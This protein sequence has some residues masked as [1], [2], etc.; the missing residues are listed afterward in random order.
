MKKVVLT[1]LSLLFV[2]FCAAGFAACDEEDAHT[3][4]LTYHAG[5]APTCAEAGNAEYWSCDGCGKNFFDADG[6]KE[7]ADVLLPATGHD[8]S[9]WVSAVQPACTEEGREERACS[10]CGGTEERSVP[11]TGHSWGAWTEHPET[12]M[13]EHTCTVCGA[14][15][16]EPI[17]ECEHVWS[18]WQT[19]L[20]PTCTQAG[21]EE[22]TCSLCGETEERSVPATGH[23]WGAWQTALLPTCTQAGREERTCSLCGGTEER[24]VPATGHKSLA[25]V[26][27]LPPT[28][29]ENGNTAYWFCSDCNT[30][31]SDA[32]GAHALK[33]GEWIL[34]ATGHNMTQIPWSYPTC[35]A[36]GVMEHWYCAD[37]DTYYSNAAGSEALEEG[38]WI[39]PATGHT[40]STEWEFDENL[41]WHESACGHVGLK[42]DE[43]P[44]SMQEGVCAVCGY[45]EEDAQGMIFK[46][47]EGGYEL[48]GVTY[49]AEGEFVVPATYRGK[50]VLSLGNNA[51]MGMRVTSVV[52][53][54][55]L[56]NIGAGA[57]DSCTQLTELVVPDSVTSMGE[58]AIAFCTSLKKLTLPFVGAARDTWLNGQI[59]YLFGLNNYIE[60]TGN[61]IPAS[62]EEV[63]VTGGSALQSY[64]LSGCKGLR[65]VTLPDGLLRVG[66]GAFSDCPALETLVLPDTLE[67]LGAWALRGCTS[68]SHILLPDG[69]LRV[70]EGAFYGCALTEISLPASIVEIPDSAFNGCASLANV[71]SGAAIEKIGGNAFYGCTSLSSF[72]FAEGLRVVG[73]SAFYASALERAE[74]PDGVTEIGYGAFQ[75]CASLRAVRI[76]ASV[77]SVGGSAFRYCPVL[78]EVTYAAALSDLGEN[79]DV[80]QGSGEEAERTVLTVAAGTQYIPARLFNEFYGLN[81]VVLPDS[82]TSIGESAFASCYALDT[83]H[84]GAGLL[85]VGA[86]AFEGCGL[87]SVRIASVAAWSAIEF[88]DAQANPLHAAGRLSTAQGEPIADIVLPEGVARIGAYAFTD[89]SS[90]SSLTIPASVRSIGAGAFRGL[91]PSARVQAVDLSAWCAIDFEDKDSNPLYSTHTLCLEGEAVTDLVLP[92]GVVSVA[93]RA[94]LGLSGLQSVAFPDGL[95]RI[96][97][98]AFY[99][100]RSLTALELPQTLVGIGASAFESAFRISSLSL[101]ASVVSVGAGAFAGCSA[102]AEL[103][104]PFLPG[105]YL[106][107]IFG[108]TSAED[109]QFSLSS[110]LTSV[111][112]AGGD[113]AEKAFY[114][115]FSLICVELGEEVSRIGA[116]AFYNCTGIEELSV[117]AGV[118]EMGENV[119]GNCEALRSLVLPFLGGTAQEQGYLGRLFGATA[120]AGQGDFLPQSLEDVTVLGGGLA[121]SAFA[122]C[123]KLG[124]VALLSVAALPERTFYGCASLADVSL[125]AGMNELGAYAFYGCTRLAGIGLPDSLSA[126]GEGAFGG[127]TRL[128]GIALPAALS[129]LGEGAF[130]GCTLLKEVTFGGGAPRIGARAFADCGELTSISLPA[131][132]SSLGAGV[133]EGCAKLAEVAIPFVGAQKNGTENTHFGYLFGAAGKEDNGESLPEYLRK[134]T[135]AHGDVAPYAFY[136]CAVLESVVLPEDLTDIGEGAF[137]NCAGLTEAEIPVGTQSIGFAAFRGC[138]GMI[139]L[140]LPF[141]GAARDAADTHFGYIFGSLK[142]DRQGED[143]PLSLRF[144]T[145]T[146]GTSV[147]ANAFFGCA[148]LGEVVLCENTASV[149]AY[150]FSGCGGLFTIT[151]PASLGS[152]GENAFTGCP[153]LLE[154]F[155][156]SALPISAGDSG[157]GEVASSAKN[158]YTQE[159]GSKYTQTQDGYLF[160]Y[161]G[162][163]LLLVD[164]LGAQTS[165]VLPEVPEAFAGIF[166]YDIAPYAFARHNSVVSVVFPG[167]SIEVGKVGYS[168]FEGCAS[169]RTVSAGTVGS[170]GTDAFSGCEKLENVVFGTVRGY[171]GE[172]AFAG[173]AALEGISLGASPVSVGADAFVGTAY[174][175][176]AQNRTDGVLYIGDHLIDAEGVS[177]EYAVREGTLSIAAGAFAGN[178]GLTSITLPAS[179]VTIGAGAFKN[180]ALASAVFA[181][182]E[183]WRTYTDI[184]CSAGGQDLSGD[185]I[186]NAETIAS[187]LRVS[188]RY[189][190][191]G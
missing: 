125:S 55:G 67:S 16:R 85:R 57:F 110:A 34:P 62:L 10:L 38:E 87:T 180:T 71:T 14:S 76:P 72:P 31:Y 90:L 146:D 120:A 56:L 47:I 160:Y 21:R 152:I 48:R 137:E 26:A 154:V 5:V 181:D 30:Y 187:D 102:I 3:H 124:F 86:G 117:P 89:L 162:E 168:A 39:L 6:T 186:A 22:R 4:T 149:G 112:V 20:L 77:V 139:R 179:L 43:A 46:A 93:P 50:P 103:S 185:R 42:K 176:D 49:A 189:W 58:G 61:S 12:G 41:H 7:A 64:A 24:S 35:E 173:C 106:G 29:T 182:T 136:G 127:C 92:A 155:N 13:R 167:G 151:L 28:C 33:E 150:A 128:A 121:P 88:A 169:L 184:G 164:C 91:D 65:S 119:F 98:E 134:V 129:E 130:G 81:E 172:G 122:E 99:G 17:S 163:K 23:S 1:V 75:R 63:T 8:W 113:I 148:Q 171:I 54:N 165:L 59:A 178:G 143:L 69:L 158:V 37:C 188:E 126:I 174:F 132:T 83:V 19:A 70:G 27:A 131:E 177:G 183:W 25:G 116:Q 118:T 40:W 51:L 11:A 107:Y 9:D 53:P 100:A 135:I 82:V 2:F 60:E 166:T 15:E 109:N 142:M 52:L 18:A 36:D 114:G 73:V 115:C 141:T 104:L 32:E 147:P 161:D 68:L 79:E 159:G 157:Y 108:G 66:E 140:S 80:F 94:F 153:K 144:V 111:S 191:K 145:L 190:K 95:E 105:G 74:L 138:D 156:K 133:F 123:D 78:A 44:H 84:V 96:G 45:E 101:P 97:E 170:I 175:A